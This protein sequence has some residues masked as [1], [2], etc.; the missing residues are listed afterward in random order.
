MS[1]PSD[2]ARLCDSDEHRAELH[3]PPEMPTANR[4][5]LT[6]DGEP[7][8]NYLCGGYKSFFTH[9][10]GRMHHG[11]PFCEKGATPTRFADVIMNTNRNEPCRAEMDAK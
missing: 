1:M 10:G 8:I 11:Q 2:C 4:F 9:A 6:P 3:Q 7:G 5:T